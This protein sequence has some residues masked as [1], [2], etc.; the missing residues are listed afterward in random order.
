M[1]TGIPLSA[2]CAW[3]ATGGAGPALGPRK[4]ETTHVQAIID[5]FYSTP[6]MI[7][8]GV[9]LLG[10]IGLLIYIRNKRTEE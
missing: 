7:I 8:N 6:G 4:T 2:R 5:Y 10:L 3:V 9:I 1:G